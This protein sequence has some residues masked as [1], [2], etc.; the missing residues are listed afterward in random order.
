MSDVGKAMGYEPAECH[1]RAQV[2]GLVQA[3][4]FDDIL[5]RLAKVQ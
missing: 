5:V 3:S 1:E 4:T 2:H